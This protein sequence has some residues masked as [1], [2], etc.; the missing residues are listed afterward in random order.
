MSK[1][2]AQLLASTFQ[3]IANDCGID[4]TIV[5][6]DCRKG[7]KCLALSDMIKDF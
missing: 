2:D 6:D 3:N 1:S 5:S 4:N 7:V